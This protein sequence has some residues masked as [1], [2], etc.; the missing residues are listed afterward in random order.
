[1]LPMT[2]PNPLPSPI[3]LP[4][5]ENLDPATLEIAQRLDVQGLKC[6]LPILRTKKLLATMTTGEVLQVLATD[7]GAV[8]DFA[9]FA[10]QTG[11]TLLASTAADGVFGFY[12]RRK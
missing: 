5:G 2:D 4:A 1:M 6:P 12:L 9:A 3:D 8:Q 11:N 7:P 10:R